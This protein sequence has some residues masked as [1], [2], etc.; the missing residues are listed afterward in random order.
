[1]PSDALIDG[2]TIWTKGEEG[3]IPGLLNKTIS[4]LEFLHPCL[5]EFNYVLRTNLSSFYVFPRLLHFLRYCPRK[6]FYCGIRHGA[7]IE[8]RDVSW[9]C[10]AGILMSSDLAE[11]LIVNKEKLLNLSSDNP[12]NV[13]DV[14]IGNL[15][16][17]NNVTITQGK[18]KEIY[19]IQTWLTLKQNIPSDL[20]HF[21]IITPPPTRI[22]IDLPIHQYL[23][24]EFYQRQVDLQEFYDYSF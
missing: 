23:L 20:F 14:M 9:V 17:E 7:N 2:D 19:S 24:H 13:D 6:R 11:M 4:S 15:F 10:G 18:Y 3:L 12:Y 16:T 5:N 1:L 21:R 22:E 8:G